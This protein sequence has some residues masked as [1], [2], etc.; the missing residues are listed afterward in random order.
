MPSID[1]TLELTVND[2]LNAVGQLNVGE[3][4]EFEIGFEQ[5]WS[6]QYSTIADTEAAVLIENHRLPVSQ[7]AQVRELLFKN[8]EGTLTKAEEEELDSYMNVMDS[9]LG[10][11]AEQILKLAES[12]QQSKSIE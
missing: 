3:L 11:T 5:I 12:R 7:Q 10:D 4:T 6:K 1:T 2:L 8:R 9:A